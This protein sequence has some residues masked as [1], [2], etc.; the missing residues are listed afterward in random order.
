MVLSHLTLAWY[1]TQIVTVRGECFT[2][3][4]QPVNSHVEY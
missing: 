2:T 3:V 1:Q 4:E